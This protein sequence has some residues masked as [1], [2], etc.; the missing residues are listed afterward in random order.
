M[1]AMI[2]LLSLFAW[3]VILLLPWGPWQ[4]REALEREVS[5]IDNQPD[6]SEIT[7]VIPARNE[8]AVIQGTL[9]CLK[10]QGNGLQVVLVDDCSTDGTTQAARQVSGLDLQI[11]AGQPL[12]AGWMGKVWA[13]NQGVA[14]VGARYTLLLD[15]DINLSRGVISALRELATKKQRSFVSIMATLPMNSFWEKLLTPAFI[16]FFK[17]LY[18]F[19]L[20]NGPNRHFASAAG[21][22]ILLETSLFKEIGGLESIREALIDDCALAARV[23]ASG[24]RTWTGQSRLVTSARGYGGLGEIWNM[25]ARSGYTQL[26]Y[27]PLI[28][29][30][31]TLAL[32]LLFIGPLISPFASS[33]PVKLA[34]L[35]AY[36]LM[37]LIYMPTLRFYSLSLLWALLMPLIGMLFLGMTWTSA[38]R[39]YRGQRSLWKDRRYTK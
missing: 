28:L 35:S 27:S 12:P 30:L 25:V 23:K 11:V 3:L 14:Q 38:I 5:V 1:I 6:L 2:V 8:A 33:L 22:C 21:G 19:G 9:A 10:E 31:T 15:A 32:L 13:L 24:A 29:L 17:M 39:Y 18:P 20:A 16:F 36:L 4:V 37:A 34:G 7:V 26:R